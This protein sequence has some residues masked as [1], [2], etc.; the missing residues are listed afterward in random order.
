MIAATISPF[1]VAKMGLSQSRRY[2]QTGE[3]IDAY[4][5]QKCGLIHDIVADERALDEWRDSMMRQMA[6]CAPEAVRKSK[7]LV[8]H[9]FGRVI[10]DELTQHT[11]EKLAE[12]RGSPEVLEG[13]TAMMEKR[14]PEWAKL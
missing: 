5:A 4:M 8:R 2:F 13:V 7:A 3:A 14:K 9:V 12:V 10:D 1:V 6:N 11:A